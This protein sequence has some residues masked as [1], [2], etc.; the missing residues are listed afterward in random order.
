MTDLSQLFL[1][2]PGIII[3]L[4]G[5]GQV[6][7]WLRMHRAGGSIDAGVV[8]CKHVVKKDK[9]GRETY[10]YYD[11]TVEYVNSGTG[12]RQ[13]HT[14]KSPTEYA[15]AQRVRL[16]TDK[17]GEN[18]ELAEYENEFLFHP[19]VTM[20]EG[21]LLII[22]ALEQNRGRQVE[23]ML[24]LA[25]VLLGA[26]IN[27]IVSYV[28]LKRRNLQAVDAQITDVYTRQISRE[29]KMLKGSRYTYYP[30][31]KFTLN[32]SENIRRCNINSSGQHT[33]QAG[34]HMKLYY[35]PGSGVVLEKHARVGAAAVGVVLVLIGLLAGASILSVIV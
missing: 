18:P 17:N 9:K 26:G 32:G 33:F 4:V 1:Y 10:N 30:I 35:D 21:A 22:L 13:R 25:F 15:M 29:T 27:L 24:C 28:S 19:W 20:I 31:V 11:V 16:L 14:M 7:G 34:D 3:F 8:G 2:I 23:A 12:H 6:R 5:S